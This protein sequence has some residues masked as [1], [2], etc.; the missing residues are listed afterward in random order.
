MRNLYPELRIKG[1]G[2]DERNEDN[3]H[4]VFNSV[5]FIYARDKLNIFASRCDHYDFNFA[6]RIYIYIYTYIY[7]HDKFYL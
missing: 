5:I 4:Q 6:K 3:S 7:V 2:D 1:G